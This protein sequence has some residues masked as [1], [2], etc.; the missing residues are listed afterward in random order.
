MNS[1][2]RE[3]REIARLK[4]AQKFHNAKYY[5]VWNI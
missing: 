5:K 1:K 3:Q 4:K 2:N